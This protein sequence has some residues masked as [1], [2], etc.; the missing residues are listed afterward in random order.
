M[1]QLAESEGLQAAWSQPVLSIA[2]GRPVGTLST[3]YRTIHEPSAHER[4]VGEVA[5]SLVAIALERTES[6]AMLAHQAT[7]DPLTGLPNRTLLLDRLEHALARRHGGAVAVLF[8]DIDRF[9]VVNDSLGH[10][11]GDEVLIG[12]AQRFRAAVAPQH[13]VARFGGDEFVVLLEHFSDDSQAIRVAHDLAAALDP[14]FVLPAG[15][16]VYLTASIGITL[17]SEDRTGDSWLRDAD[18]AMYRAKVDGRN[19]HVVFDADMRRAALERLQVE[20][21]LRHAVANAELLVHY[22]AVVDLRSGRIAGAEALV[23]WQHPERGLLAPG[24]FMAIAE[25]AGLARAVDHHV[26]EVAVAAM[27]PVVA[28]RPGFQL[29]VNA[30]GRQIG[31]YGLADLVEA[32]CAAHGFPR[33][34]LILEITESA[35]LEGAEESVEQLQRLH[36][37]GVGLAIDDFG[38]G[39]SSLTRLARVPVS[40][41][42]IDQSFVATIDQPGPGSVGIVDAVTAMA[43]A[44]GLQAIGEGVESRAQLEH[45]RRVGCDFGQGYYFSKP[46]PLEEFLPLIESDPVW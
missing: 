23:R 31:A 11:V 10:G 46:V 5:C 19:R 35:I 39:S 42:K 41:V 38:T 25:D 9:K 22:Q 40:K 28:R 43:R 15:Q 24:D 13:T 29:G 20:S 37:L 8:C 32:T 45:L 14:P 33:H 26:L 16:E 2:T 3:L 17:S 18:A 21:D 1:R 6:E 44:L 12:F 30:S 34:A 4:R 36:A 27:A 7:H